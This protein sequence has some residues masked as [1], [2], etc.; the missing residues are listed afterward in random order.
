MLVAM[1]QDNFERL[2]PRMIDEYAVT[3]IEAGIWS[4]EEARLL[5]QAEFDRLIPEGMTTP[6]NHFME[7]RTTSESP[8]VAGMAWFAIVGA[9]PD[10]FIYLLYL[11]VE[12]AWRRRGVAAQAMHDL[13]DLARGLG[14]GHVRLH[15]FAQNQA[16]RCLYDRLGYAVTGLNMHKRVGKTG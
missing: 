13:E 6:N 12:P 11:Y 1:R 3:N 16:A 15:V 2:L 8:D 10:A 7:I 14:L 5:A 4:P 9:V